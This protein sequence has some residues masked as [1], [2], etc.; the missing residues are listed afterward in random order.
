METWF[1]LSQ[2]SS[3]RPGSHFLV[4]ASPDASSPPPPAASSI[5]FASPFPPSVPA[6][7]PVASSSHPSVQPPSSFSLLPLGSLPPVSTPPRASASPPPV[8]RN[9]DAFALP[10]WPFPSA[11]LTPLVHASLTQ[12]T[13]LLFL[14][15]AV[16]GTLTVQC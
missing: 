1:S 4:V 14:P 9:P 5:T 13:W 12:Q 15:Q 2:S 6:S 11:S 16:V 3:W 8:S 7:S 10:S